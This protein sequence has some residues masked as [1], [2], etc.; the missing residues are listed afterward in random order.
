MGGK[1]FLLKNKKKQRKRLIV[2]QEMEDWGADW[3][4]ESWD[5]G[6][7]LECKMLLSCEMLLSGKKTK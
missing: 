7:S 4:M 2:F 5:T 6:V 3:D 1:K